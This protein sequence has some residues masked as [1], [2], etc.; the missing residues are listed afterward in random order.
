VLVA[1]LVKPNQVSRAA[2]NISLVR[3]SRRVEMLTNQRN[4]R[5]ES[6]EERRKAGRQTNQMNRQMSLLL[7]LD[8]TFNCDVPSLAPSASVL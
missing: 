6:K 4:E 7:A 3:R 1:K 2:M 5:K 8:S